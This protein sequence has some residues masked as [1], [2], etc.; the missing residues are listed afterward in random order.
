MLD[1]ECA[2]LSVTFWSCLPML[3]RSSSFFQ[4]SSSPATIFGRYN[5]ESMPPL[6]RDFDCLLILDELTCMVYDGLDDF[7]N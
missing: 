5:F 2:F 1:D 7:S 4:V 3:I 6:V